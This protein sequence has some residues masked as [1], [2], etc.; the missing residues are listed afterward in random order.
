[1]E[2]M[3][4]DMGKKRIRLVGSGRRRKKGDDNGWA[5]MND[6]DDCKYYNHPCL[7]D[8]ALANVDT[9]C[10]AGCPKGLRYSPDPKVLRQVAVAFGRFLEEYDGQ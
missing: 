3:R 4:C 8:A 1:M 9:V 10:G 5:R 6:H 2:W 7:T